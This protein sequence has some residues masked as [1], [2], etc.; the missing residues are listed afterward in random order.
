MISAQF[1][2]CTLLVDRDLWGPITRVVAK[3][4]TPFLAAAAGIK[5]VLIP[6]GI[7][8]GF[9]FRNHR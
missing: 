5:G 1:M 7:L 3:I 9:I 2:K 8:D 4:P 6:S